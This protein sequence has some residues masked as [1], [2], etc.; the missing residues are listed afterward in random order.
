MSHSHWKYSIISFSK[1]QWI[2]L[3]LTLLMNPRIVETL[4][5]TILNKFFLEFL[6]YLKIVTWALPSAYFHLF[7]T[8]R[9]IE[10]GCNVVSTHQAYS[11]YGQIMLICRCWSYKKIAWVR[12]LKTYHCTVVFWFKQVVGKSKIFA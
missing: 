11:S 10:D 4:E 3:F 12:I 1:W 7:A 5:A 8:L 9:I 6:S 2:F